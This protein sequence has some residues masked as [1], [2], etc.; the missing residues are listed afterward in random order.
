M[1]IAKKRD[2]T[3]FTLT[4]VA[5]ELTA[6]CVYDDYCGKEYPKTEANSSVVY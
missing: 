2:R 4:A 3:S 5:V 6:K 1:L